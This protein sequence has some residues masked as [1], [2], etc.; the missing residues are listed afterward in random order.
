MANASPSSPR[1]AEL[2]RMLQTVR[3]RPESPARLGEEARLLHFLA[4]ATRDGGQRDRY[5]EQGRALAKRALAEDPEQ[6][7]AL[8]W[9]TAH[10]GA[11]ATALNP[12]Q[13]VKIAKEI[14]QTL[15]RLRAVAPEYDSSAADRVLGIVYQV[16]PAVVSIGSKEKAREHLNAALRRHPEHP[17]NLL[18]AAKYL[19]ENGDCPKAKDL[20]Q[21]VLASGL[22]ADPLEG[23][24]WR[25]EAQAVLE[26]ASRECK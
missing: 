23:P 20:S 12:F 11:Q 21:K 25:A 8:L 10:R 9:W 18:S 16:A 26:R 13:A 3:A 5:R 6:P 15:L 22:L 24:L 7:A 4:E 2:E 17:G 1:V 19:L 14:E